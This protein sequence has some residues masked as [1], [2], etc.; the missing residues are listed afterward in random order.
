[1]CMNYKLCITTAVVVLNLSSCTVY[2]P[3]EPGF[4]TLEAQAATDPPPNAIVGM[5]HDHYNVSS[6]SGPLVRSLLVKADGTGLLRSKNDNAEAKQIDIRWTYQ[7]SGWWIVSYPSESYAQTK[8]RISGDSLLEYPPPHGGLD[9][10]R[11]FVRGTDS[12]AVQRDRQSL[13]QPLP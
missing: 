12:S 9:S 2:S 13:G 7:G 4:V 1:M 6:F 5:W 10:R 3:L 11:V 8:F